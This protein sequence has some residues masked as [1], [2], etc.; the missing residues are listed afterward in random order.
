MLAVVFLPLILPPLL[1]QLYVI[2]CFGLKLLT[3]ALM[4]TGSPTITS[5]GCAE[6]LALGGT[7]ASP[8]AKLNTTPVRSRAPLKETRRSVGWSGPTNCAK[9]W[10]AHW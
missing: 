10:R 2:V 7:G 4:V 8:A 5:A 1:V 9:F 6:Q 3:F